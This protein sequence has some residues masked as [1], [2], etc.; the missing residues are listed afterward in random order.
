MVRKVS[1]Q[2]L[3]LWEETKKEKEGSGR[4]LPKGVSRL[5][6]RLNVSVLGS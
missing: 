3:C 1:D 2:D 5:S 4:H 6:H